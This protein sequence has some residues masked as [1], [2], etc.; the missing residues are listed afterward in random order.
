MSYDAHDER[1]TYPL[2]EAI[3]GREI[4]QRGKQEDMGAGYDDTSGRR[5]LSEHL[6]ICDSDTGH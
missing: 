4:D 3:S 5:T 1:V 2:V 6:D